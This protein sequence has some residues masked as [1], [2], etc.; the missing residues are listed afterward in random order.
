MN[1]KKLLKALYTALFGLTFYSLV[2]LPLNIWLSSAEYL[3]LQYDEKNL[4]RRFASS[5]MKV[6]GW[7]GLFF[8]SLI[9]LSYILG[10][11]LIISLFF[12]NFPA[13]EIMG[14]MFFVGMVSYF[15]PIALSFFK[16]MI[17]LRLLMYFKLENIEENTAGLHF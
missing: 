13:E 3:S 1:Y 15:S 8:N 5:E 10:V 6:L 16:E 9:F 17:S 12:K 2:S 14:K 7:L 11:L 4:T